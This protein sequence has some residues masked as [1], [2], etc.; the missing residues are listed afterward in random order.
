MSR[1][2]ST[3][4]RSINSDPPFS[5]P[6]RAGLLQKAY[7]ASA[8]FS[9]HLSIFSHPSCTTILISAFLPPGFYHVSTFRLLPVPKLMQV[10]AAVFQ[11]KTLFAADV[12]VLFLFL[13]RLQSCKTHV[14]QDSSSSFASLIYPP[15]VSYNIH[16]IPVSDPTFTFR[17]ARLILCTCSRLPKSES[18]NS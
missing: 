3:W 10:P 12:S 1:Y 11:K 4:I 2:G 16:D 6:F 14:A 17:F 13:L 15:P 7:M 5:E 8:P 18:C 9:P